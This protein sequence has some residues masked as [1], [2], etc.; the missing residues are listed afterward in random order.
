MLLPGSGYGSQVVNLIR[1]SSV[2]VLVSSP[3]IVEVEIGF[4]I[5]LF[6]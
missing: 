3:V 5:N 2:K 6:Y 1:G 4:E